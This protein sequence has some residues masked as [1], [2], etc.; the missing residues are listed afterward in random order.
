MRYLW[1]VPLRL[2]NDRLIELLGK[3]PHTPLDTAIR[4]VLMGQ[5]C[6]AADGKETAAVAR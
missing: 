1:K 2:R 4:T 6:L 3:E 5:G